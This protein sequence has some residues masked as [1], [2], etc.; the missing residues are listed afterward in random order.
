M[1]GKPHYLL[2]CDSRLSVP[3]F[4][5]DSPDTLIGLGRWH[6]V[7]ERLD[8]PERLEAFDEEPHIHR[9]RIA[10]LSVV[11]GLEAADETSRI[12]LVTT[13][14]YVD[15]GLRFGLQNWRETNFQWESFGL[16]KPIRNADLWERIDTALQYHELEC[17]LIGAQSHLALSLLQKTQTQKHD[18][19][20]NRRIVR[21]AQGALTSSW[22]AS[23]LECQSGP[24]PVEKLEAYPPVKTAARVAGTQPARREWW[25]MAASWL[26]TVNRANGHPAFGA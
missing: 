9:D 14:R 23:P 7:L 24:G 17:R 26:Q 11:R 8:A 20:R 21:P 6:F 5:I 22:S 2:Y 13:S 25:E 18:A 4:G 19:I 15:R 1:V 12:E 10:L 3:G 16:L